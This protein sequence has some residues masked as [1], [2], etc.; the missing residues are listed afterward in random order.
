MQGLCLA[1]ASLG[2]CMILLGGTFEGE[3]ARRLVLLPTDGV[4]YPGAS[5]RPVSS[6][7]AR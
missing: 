6:R 7:P 5:G 3:I 2:L 4:L 1:S